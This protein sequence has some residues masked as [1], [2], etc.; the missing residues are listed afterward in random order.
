M[1]DNS[2]KH[3]QGVWLDQLRNGE[4]NYIEKT[5]EKHVKTIHYS[6]YFGNRRHDVKEE[7]ITPLLNVC[8]PSE[9]DKLHLIYDEKK[10]T[11]KP[12]INNDDLL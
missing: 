2:I 12:E 1:A 11:K 7:W 3:W 6:M 5:P 10:D 8:S 9:Q 4:I